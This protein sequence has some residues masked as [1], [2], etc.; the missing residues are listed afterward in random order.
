[1]C[2]K[3][4]YLNSRVLLYRQ[5]ELRALELKLLDLDKVGSEKDQITLRSREMDERKSQERGLLI[6][7]IDQKLKEYNDVVQRIRSFAMLQRATERNYNTVH[8]WIEEEA[9]LV[10]E[11]AA[12]FNKER[13]F[14]AVVDV[15]EGAWFESR[16]ETMLSRFGGSFI[17]VQ[18]SIS[19]HI[20]GGDMNIRAKGL[21]ST[22][23]LYREARS[24]QYR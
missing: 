1:M 24:H 9:P 2:R 7:K 20:Y 19:R 3:Y 15:K 17:R 18:S 8:H 16:V 5:D 6:N 10:Q 22:A 11:E 4:G 14:V 13:D 21:L 23:P 12:T